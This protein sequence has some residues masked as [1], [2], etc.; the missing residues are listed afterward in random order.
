MCNKQTTKRF[1]ILLNHSPPLQRSLVM[2]VFRDRPEMRI[3]F[4]ESKPN[5]FLTRSQLQ[6]LGYKPNP[7]QQTYL[8]PIEIPRD[9]FLH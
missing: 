3:L 5:I 8:A 9:W 2:G 7:L 4:E 6:E 1:F